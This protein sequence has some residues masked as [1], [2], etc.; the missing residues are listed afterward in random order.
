[1][2]NLSVFRDGKKTQEIGTEKDKVF[3][4]RDASCDVVLD[5]RTTSRK[6]ASVTVEEDG[7]YLEDLDSRNGTFIDGESVKRHKLSGD[8]VIQVGGY[9]ISVGGHP[10][11]TRRIRK[12]ER[13]A[14][15]VK[16]EDLPWRRRDHALFVG[17]APVE[18][19]RYACAVVVE[20]GGGGSKAAAPIAKDLL[21]EV[22]RRDPAASDPMPLVARATRNT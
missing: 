6:H 15:V 1:M 10:A 8:D 21:L 19:P 5:D 7:V 13:D 4:G 16:N 20:H 18:A 9:Q 2:L 22:Q 11:L 14:G 12:A 3:I 17:F